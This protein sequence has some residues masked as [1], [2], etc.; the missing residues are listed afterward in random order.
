M[1]IGQQV[2]SC[3]KRSPV[4]VLDADFT[5]VYLPL[6]SATSTREEV[7]K[8]LPSVQK[9]ELFNEGKLSP[10]EE[11]SLQEL[12]SQYN[13]DETACFTKGM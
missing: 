13:V 8:L 10:S 1:K 5:G 9:K 3:V 12:C 4:A 7:D 6:T 11:R 2:L